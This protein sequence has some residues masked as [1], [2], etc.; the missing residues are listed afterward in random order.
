MANQCY[1][2]YSHNHIY[3]DEQDNVLYKIIL[4]K[5]FLFS[6]FQLSTLISSFLFIYPNVII[7]F[8]FLPTSGKVY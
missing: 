5:L 3:Y 4:T 2:N 6:L 7:S 8:M 1:I